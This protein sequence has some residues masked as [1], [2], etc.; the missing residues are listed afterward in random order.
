MVTPFGQLSLGDQQ[1]LSLAVGNELAVSTPLKSHHS[2]IFSGTWL[3]F[4]SLSNPFPCQN[5]PKRPRVK[6]SP[7]VPA[8]KRPR[9]SPRQNVLERPRVKTSSNV[10]ISSYEGRP[11]CLSVD[12]P[13]HRIPLRAQ[14]SPQHLGR[15]IKTM[16][17]QRNGRSQPNSVTTISWDERRARRVLYG[18]TVRATFS[19]RPTNATISRGKQTSGLN[20]A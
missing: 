6:T 18:P 20:A 12:P 5:V 16:P 13:A 17:Q 2:S 14:P 19:R 7:N 15:L 4:P 11:I 9:T 10:P 3:V 8:S 1:A